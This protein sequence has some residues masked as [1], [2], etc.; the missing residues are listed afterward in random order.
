MDYASKAFILDTSDALRMKKVGQGEVEEKSSFVLCS[1][2]QL[3]FKFFFYFPYS[4]EFFEYFSA[5]K[6]R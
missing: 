6:T 2:E 3:L 4:L 1:P 5:K